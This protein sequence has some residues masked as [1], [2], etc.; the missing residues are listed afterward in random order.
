ME[1]RRLGH[2]G[3]QLSVLSYGS[4][5]T[6]HKQVDDSIADA[7]M[8]TAYDAGINFFDN[9]EGYAGGE[10]EKMMGRVLKKKNWDRTSYLISSKVFFGLHGNKNKPNQGGLSRKHIVECCHGAL[11][12]L[13]HDYLD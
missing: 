1:Y 3:V 13:Q 11:E 4:W 9:A 2:S 10:S 8:G 5:V 12:R 7:L 6:F